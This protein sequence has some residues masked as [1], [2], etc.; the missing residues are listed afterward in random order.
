MRKAQNRR[1]LYRERRGGSSR[2]R[3][4]P[5][6]TQRSSQLGAVRVRS[7]LKHPPWQG[8]RRRIPHPTR[9]DLVDPRV[10]IIRSIRDRPGSAEEARLMR[11]K[12]L[13]ETYSE[14]SPSLRLTHRGHRHHLVLQVRLICRKTGKGTTLFPPNV[15]VKAPMERWCHCMGLFKDC[16]KLPNPTLV[17]VPL[18][19]RHHSRHIPQRFRLGLARL[20]AGRWVWREG[21]RRPRT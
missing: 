11:H 20:V 7:H 21:Q 18:F 16:Q 10:G 19:Q 14:T 15:M 5:T 2:L 4:S 6:R 1:G 17:Q 12:T 9:P 3:P 8:R 13:R